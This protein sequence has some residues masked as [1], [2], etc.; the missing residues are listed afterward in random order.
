MTPRPTCTRHGLERRH[1][2]LLVVATCLGWGT[3]TTTATEAPMVGTGQILRGR[4]IQERRLQGFGKPLLSEGRFTLAPG[5]G[6]IWQLEHP[7]ASLLAIGPHGLT[8]RVGDNETLRLNVAQLPFLDTL[9]QVFESALSGSS[10]GLNALFIVHQ[11]ADVMEL[12]PR[13][14]TMQV[15]W[16]IQR[17]RVRLGR[18][19]DEVEI[20]KENGD[21]DLLHFREQVLQDSPLEK[22]EQALLSA[23]GS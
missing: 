4:F 18:F 11:E 1:F 2:L 13:P 3:H 19:V 5:Q 14:S 7:F 8:Q 20:W 21:A 23:A 12:T 22:E 9:R 15:E 17:L 6:L 10:T 16:R